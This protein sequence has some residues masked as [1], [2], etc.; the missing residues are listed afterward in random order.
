[1]IFVHKH[2]LADL[3]QALHE[4]LLGSQILRADE[5]TLRVL[6]EDTKKCYVWV[7]RTS[8]DTE[9]PVILYDYQPSRAGTCASAFLNGFPG[10][11]HTDGYEAYHCKLPPEITVAGCWAHMRQKFTDA[12]KSLPEEIREKHSAHK[13][14]ESCNPLFALEEEYTKDALSFQERHD[15]RLQ[16]SKPVAKE[17]FAWAKAEEMTNP[18]PKTM[19]GAALGYALNQEGWLMNVFWTDGWSCP[20]TGRNALCVRSPLT[21]RTGCSAIL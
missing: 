10:L 12:L 5:T 19:Y 20:T 17:F 11:L 4:E 18:V 16:H 6:G 7:Y 15:A 1:M 13:G 21:G 9:R 14:L 3:I 2:Y 8:G